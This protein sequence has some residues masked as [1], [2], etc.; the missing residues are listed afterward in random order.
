MITS[1]RCAFLNKVVVLEEGVRLLRDVD[2]SG[3]PGRLHLVGQRHVVGPDQGKQN[4]FKIQWMAVSK[5]DTHE[6]ISSL[7]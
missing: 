3:L 7:M 1:D 5:S 4:S 2:G 6:N